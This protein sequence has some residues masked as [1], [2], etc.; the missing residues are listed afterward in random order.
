VLPEDAALG[1][2]DKTLG[3]EGGAGED[4]GPVATGG[5]EQLPEDQEAHE[6]DR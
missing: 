2:G 4:K 5:D 1:S 6:G 3:Y